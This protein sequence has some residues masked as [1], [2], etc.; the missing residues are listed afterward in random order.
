MDPVL[1]GYSFNGWY[2][3]PSLTRSFNEVTMPEEDI[4]LYAKWV[5]E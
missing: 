3:D 5:L 1:P 2:T 4:T